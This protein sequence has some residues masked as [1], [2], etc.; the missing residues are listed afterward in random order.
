LKRVRYA[1]VS[2]SYLIIAFDFELQQ[3]LDDIILDFTGSC[4]ER[5]R[6]IH[7]WLHRDVVLEDQV[8]LFDWLVVGKR[9]LSV[10]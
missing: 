5:L 6:C 7:S 9:E 10:A 3:S 1:R 2:M 8:R 4:L